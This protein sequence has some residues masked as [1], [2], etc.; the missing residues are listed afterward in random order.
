VN[1]TG[2]TF[3]WGY[4]PVYRLK[5]ETMSGGSPA[6]PLSYGLDLVGNRTNRTSTISGLTNQNFTFNTNDWLTSDSYDSN[7]NTTS[8]SGIASQYD[9]LDHM[10][11][12]N[13]GAVLITY[14]GDGNR[15]RKTVGSTTTLY[16][17]DDRNPSG[18]PQVVEEWT[19][20]G[21]VT[22]LSRVY[23]YGLQ[24]IRQ[25]EPSVSTNYFI[26]DGHGSTRM[27]TDSGGVVVNAFAY[28]AHGNLIASNTAPQTVYLFGSQE[29]DSDL[30]L[31]YLRARYHNP[32]TGRF[33]TRDTYQGAQ[34]NPKSL[35][36]YVY[37]VGDPVNRIDPSGNWAEETLFSTATEFTIQNRNAVTAQAGRTLATKGIAKVVATTAIYSIATLRLGDV[38]DKAPNSESVYRAM[39]EDGG[40]PKVGDT[41]R[42]LGVRLGVDISPALNGMVTPG[43]EGMSVAPKTPMNLPVFRRPRILLGTGKDPVWGMDTSLLGWNLTYRQDS[44]THG[45]IEPAMP[46]PFTMFQSF[47][48]ETRN[49]WLKVAPGN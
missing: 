39:T 2:R 9:P 25:R 48:S 28:D 22:N 12:Y 37:C 44:P 1:G 35:H 40:F 6:G 17:W 7:G 21:G 3:S 11:N 4:N 49:R 27:L 10:T 20:S 45:L 36:K 30:S 15:V 31:Y 23:D 38:E 13:S 42:T 47:L 16:V 5:Q 34:E 24:L 41:A 18:Y 26:F 32:N 19:G 33:W 46:M 29:W 8:S 14:D 43:T